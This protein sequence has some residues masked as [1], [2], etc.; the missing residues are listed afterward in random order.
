MNKCTPETVTAKTRS[1]LP[2]SAGPEMDRPVVLVGLMGVGKTSVGR[3]LS[4]LLGMVFVDADDEIVKA[5]G[6]SIDD[7]FKIYG[8]AAF[9][10][11]EKRVIERLL[12][13]QN[14]VL[15]TGGGAFMDASTRDLIKNVAVSVWLGADVGVLSERTGRRGGRPLLENGNR[16]QI[17]EN[18]LRER[19]PFYR[20]ADI[21]VD[22]GDDTLDGTA[23]R[24]RS[25][26]EQWKK[27]H[28]E[29]KV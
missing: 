9:R 21:H 29:G 22:S 14:L 1:T 19:E 8:E 20:Q 23:Q 3:R 27:N 18:L 13:D 7:I 24:I 17:L 10:D 4:K 5:A 25:A 26:L 6:C 11:V 12:M 15:A 16:E 28:N 2:E